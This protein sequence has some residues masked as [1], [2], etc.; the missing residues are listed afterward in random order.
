[1]LPCSEQRE[2]ILRELVQ[3]LMHRELPKL[4][5]V[6]QLA[7]PE[8]RE[9]YQVNEQLVVI[10][11]VQQQ[12]LESQVLEQPAQLVLQ[13]LELQQ[14]HLVQKYLVELQALVL[15]AFRPLVHPLLE[16]RLHLLEDCSGN[17]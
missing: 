13:Q 11:L 1:M 12:V 17:K 8:L 7:E 14:V 15:V 10:A 4:E 6:L 16:Q 2:Q 9:L 3:V 5:L